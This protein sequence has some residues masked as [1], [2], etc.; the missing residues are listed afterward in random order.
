MDTLIILMMDH[1]RISILMDPRI[2]IILVPSVMSILTFILLRG[3]LKA[4]E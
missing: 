4:F 1:P 3:I 2:S